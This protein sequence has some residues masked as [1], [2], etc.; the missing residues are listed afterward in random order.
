[1]W[2][3]SSKASLAP[4]QTEQR[5]NIVFLLVI[6]H[7]VKSLLS[8]EVTCD[9]DSYHKSFFQ[10]HILISTS[11]Y[12]SSFSPLFDFVLNFHC[13]VPSGTLHALAC[14]TCC[15]FLYLVVLCVFASHV[16]LYWQRGFPIL[17]VFVYLF[18]LFKCI[19]HVSLSQ[20]AVVEV[21]T[22]P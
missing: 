8:L 2:P 14:A 1:M 10:T 16:L 6:L 3:L 5:L 19:L 22:S 4:C 7:G 12:D 21:S 18:V 17:L 13:F 11:L 9:I 20:D 15:V